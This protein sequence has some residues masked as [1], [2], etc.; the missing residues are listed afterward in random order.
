[1]VCQREI[2]KIERVDEQREFWQSGQK[3]FIYLDEIRIVG[4]RDHISRDEGFT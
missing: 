2:L 3:P 1:M 4:D